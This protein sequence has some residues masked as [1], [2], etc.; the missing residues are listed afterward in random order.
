MVQPWAEVSD[1]ADPLHPLANQVLES[2]SFILYKLTAEKY[3]GIITVREAYNA[4]DSV[5]KTTPVLVQGK[6]MNLPVSSSRGNRRELYLRNKPARRIISITVNGKVQ[7]VD[8]YQ[9]RNFSYIIKK[10]G[11]HWTFTSHDEVIVEYE[12]GNKPPKIGEEA[13]IKLANELIL[14]IEN[15]PNCAIPANVT[16][17]SRQGMSFQM[18]D[19]QI[20]IEQGRTGIREVDLFIAATNPTKARKQSRLFTPNRIIG[21]TI[22]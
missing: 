5:V 17:V 18:T 22:Q 19:P 7:N 8:D 6:M 14:A 15:D 21:E 10:N 12:Y 13:A 16:S 4:P 2:A 20:F 9:L 11:Q 3:P 1:L